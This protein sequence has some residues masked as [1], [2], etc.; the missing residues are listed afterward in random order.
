MTNIFRKTALAGLT[1]LA[2][3]GAGCGKN[4]N[5]NILTED[6]FFKAEWI[7]APYK[8]EI[9]SSYM[10]EKIPRYNANWKIYQRMIA[11]RNGFTYLEKDGKR[12]IIGFREKRILLPDLDSDEYVVSGKETARSAE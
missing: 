7:S 8:G 2:L 3:G 10:G 9:W 5:P 12:Y 11:E 1:A 6:D 4:K